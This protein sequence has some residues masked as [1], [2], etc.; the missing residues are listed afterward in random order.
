MDNGAEENMLI[1]LLDTSGPTAGV[2]LWQDGDIRYEALL[3][4]Q[5]THSESALSMTEEAYLKTGLELADTDY[6]AVIAGPGSFTGVRIG[7]T[8][9]KALARA[10]HKPC[11]ALS[12]LEA[13]AR[14]QG[15]F[16][17]LICPM[18]N[19]RRNQVYTALFDGLSGE[20]IEDDQ[21]AML[22]DWVNDALEKAEGRRVLL[23]GD[24]MTA[25]RDTLEKLSD[26][27]L[28]LADASHAYLRPA[29]AAVLAS[30][31]IGSAVSSDALAPIYLRP[32][33]AVRQKN[34]VEHAHD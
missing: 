24:G 17:G 3:H 32:P 9:V 28:I 13:M 19:A 8:T 5:L 11:I 14:S 15:A 16:D 31:R 12:A 21:P 2:A 7:V 26:D 20:R 33:Q 29:S 10:H 6:F 23:T 30:E 18:Q 27:R 22:L 25:Y 4:H 34:L 1:Y